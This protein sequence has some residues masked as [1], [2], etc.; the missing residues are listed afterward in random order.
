MYVSGIDRLESTRAAA[1]R[2]GVE[3]ARSGLEGE[4]DAEYPREIIFLAEFDI[5]GL[6][7]PKG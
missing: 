3:Q 4:S 1:L 6:A 5:A 7:C 2:V